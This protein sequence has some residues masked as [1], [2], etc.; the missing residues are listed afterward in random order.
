MSTVQLKAQT[1]K[2]PVYQN[3]VIPLGESNKFQDFSF[4]NLVV[5]IIVLLRQSFVEIRLGMSLN[6]ICTTYYVTA[7][8]LYI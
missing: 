1:I 5:H 3:I 4:I 6:Q 2:L 7:Y 8:E